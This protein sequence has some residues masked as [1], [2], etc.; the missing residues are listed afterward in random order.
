MPYVL[1]FLT[2]MDK[3]LKE[4]LAVSAHNFPDGG[5]TGIRRSRHFLYYGGEIA[6]LCFPP[7]FVLQTLQKN[8]V[9]LK[10]VHVYRK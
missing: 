2:E 8:D 6:A 5:H 9:P 1:L 7:G 4:G 3:I 10:N